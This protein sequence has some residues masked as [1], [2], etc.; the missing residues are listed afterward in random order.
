[1]AVFYTDTLDAIE[2]WLLGELSESKKESFSKETK[3]LVEKADQIAAILEHLSNEK[4]DR[5]FPFY[6]KQD[7]LSFIRRVTQE[8]AKRLGILS[9]EELTDRALTELILEKLKKGSV[10]SYGNHN[11]IDF[12]QAVFFIF[13]KFF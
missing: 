5:T 11:H 12:I 13:K 4:I 10:E 8:A 2:K 1:M 3:N 9:P 7:A 6:P